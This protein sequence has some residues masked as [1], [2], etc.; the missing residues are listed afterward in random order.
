MGTDRRV[1]SCPKFIVS[2]VGLN[3]R[4]TPQPFYRAI[5]SR[6]AR[7]ILARDRRLY[8]RWPGASWLTP[9]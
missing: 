1:A 3:E 5:L 7:R 4:V 9:L 8:E 6:T 2:P